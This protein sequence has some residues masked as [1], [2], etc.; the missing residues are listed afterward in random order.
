MDAGKGPCFAAKAERA[1]SCVR[2]LGLSAWAAW[3][4]ERVLALLQRQ[5]VQVVV[6]AI[7]V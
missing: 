7:W 2:D 3:T 5:S 1:G 4:L 6:Y